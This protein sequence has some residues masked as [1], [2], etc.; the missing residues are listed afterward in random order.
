M[1][2]EHPEHLKD[3]L[4]EPLIYGASSGVEMFRHYRNMLEHQ[5][6]LK[7]LEA[8]YLKGYSRF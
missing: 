2:P 8:T 1:R 6:L 4:L 3:D 7:V 5:F